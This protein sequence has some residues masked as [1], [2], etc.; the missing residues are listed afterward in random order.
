MVVYVGKNRGKGRV[1]FVVEMYTLVGR[2]SK[3]F[4]RKDP[5][6]VHCLVFQVKIIRIHLR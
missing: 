4:R 5:T 6:L 3:P 2:T 1:A